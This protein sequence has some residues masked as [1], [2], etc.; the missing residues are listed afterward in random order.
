MPQPIR[1]SRVTAAAVEQHLARARRARG[2]IPI[3]V[4]ARLGHLGI[5][6]ALL[7]LGCSGSFWAFLK[8]IQL[9][10]KKGWSNLGA[11]SN[12]APASIVRTMQLE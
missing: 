1:D 11:S 4:Q 3:V 7:S 10:P 9:L 2:R 6:L 5:D 12:M 8:R